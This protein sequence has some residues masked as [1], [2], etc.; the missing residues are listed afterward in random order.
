MPHPEL[1]PGS[2]TFSNR[3]YGDAASFWRLPTIHFGLKQLQDIL[4][5]GQILAGFR[6]EQYS[7]WTSSLAED[8]FSLVWT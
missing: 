4:I 7:P 5:P 8:L 6:L 2:L 3:K 1:V